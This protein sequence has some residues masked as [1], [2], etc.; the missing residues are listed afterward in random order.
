MIALGIFGMGASLLGAGLARTLV[1]FTLAF[2]VYSPASGLAC[3]LAQA[4]LM[5]LDPERREQRMA[6]WTLSGTLGDLFAPAAIAGAVL[7]FGSYRFAWLIVGAGLLLIALLVARAPL[8][9]VVI[10]DEEATGGGTLAKLAGNRA[11][12]AWLAGASL[13]GL[14]DETLT[15]FGALF[16]A[17]RFPNTPLVVTTALTACTLGSV[18]GLVA[19]QRWLERVS[20]KP[21]LAFACVGSVLAYLAFLATATVVTATFWMFVVGV[22]MSWQYPLAQAL[23][24]RAAGERSG[25]VAVATPL[26]STFELVAPIT[27]GLVADRFGL[28]ATLAC[29]LAQPVGLLI[30][31]AASRKRGDP[32]REW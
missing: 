18:V 22:L 2:A 24:Y 9:A 1:E 14:L 10:E 4:A 28:T 7:V 8:P 30:V 23:A 21:L 19:L 25:L 26:F 16:L 20:A 13:C 6:A 11:L 12:I 15:A 17:D 27:L 5:D 32:A 3:G 29:L 31:L